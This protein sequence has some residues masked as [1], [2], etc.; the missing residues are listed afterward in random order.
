MNLALA[1][2][3]HLHRG[4]VEPEVGGVELLVEGSQSASGKVPSGPYLTSKIS[5]PLVVPT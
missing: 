4:L 2:R 5:C 1:F 3:G